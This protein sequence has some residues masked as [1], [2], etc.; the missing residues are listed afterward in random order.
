MCNSEIKIGFWTLPSHEYEH[1]YIWQLISIEIAKLALLSKGLHFLMF[2][3][4]LHKYHFLHMCTCQEPMQWQ[5]QEFTQGAGRPPRFIKFVCQHERIG[6]LRR[7]GGAPSGSATAM[8]VTLKFLPLKPSMLQIQISAFHKDIK[9][10][11]LLLHWPYMRFFILSS[12]IH[13]NRHKN[14]FNLCL[15][16]HNL[17]QFH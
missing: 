1:E 15:I 3:K 8:W 10:Q 9:N 6:T 16:C 11:W 17:S 2:I 4:M 7:G 12:L 5:I 13:F 14:M